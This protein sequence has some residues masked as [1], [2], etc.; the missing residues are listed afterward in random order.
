[1]N[2]KVH[3]KRNNC[4]NIAVKSVTNFDKNDCVGKTTPIDTLLLPEK[5]IK[6]G[7]GADSVIL[8]PYKY[9]GGQLYKHCVSVKRM[10][11]NVDW[12][13]C[14]TLG[15]FLDINN[16]KEVIA[17]SDD[18]YLVRDE[19]R[20]KGTKH[21]ENCYLVYL[22]GELFGHI[23]TTPR[24]SILDSNLSLF[25]IEN[26]ILYQRGWLAR[27]DYILDS[28]GIEKYNVSRLDIAIDGAG[29][30]NDYEGLVAR[31]YDKVGR[32]KMTTMHE[33]NGDV[34]GF[35][36][37]SR[38]SVKF[39]RCYDKT[40][41]LKANEGKGYI[42][43]WWQK[44]NLQVSQRVERLELSIKRGAIKLIKDFDYSKL[45]N[46]AYLAGVMKGLFNGLYQFREKK[47][48]DSNV[49]RL[50]KYDAVDWS[51]FD[52]NDV[53]RVSKTNKPN[54][55]WAAQQTISFT[56]RES[57]AGLETKGEDLWDSAYKRS[58]DL[59]V[60]YGILDWFK[61]K[62]NKWKKEKKY[63]DKMRSE[64]EY[65]KSTRILIGNSKIF[66]DS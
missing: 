9:N 12:F 35:Y 23:N 33:A 28:I 3:Q 7:S 43:Q 26:Y 8:T 31:K 13:E 22:H 32:A 37:G 30:I 41:E 50:K 24:A 42:K 46:S 39:I 21:F 52:A 56:M 44:N 4:K 55:I 1:M 5:V 15:C 14:S 18:V 58:F 19:K 57:Y 6:N 65:A 66:T 63:H 17:C 62:L 16:P 2:A 48:K 45:E 61:S 54:V 40:K 36:I 20:P 25:K 47:N 49:S 59:A 29:F 64:V 11:I 27:F 10:V 51:Y 38:S 60:K 34:E 53:D